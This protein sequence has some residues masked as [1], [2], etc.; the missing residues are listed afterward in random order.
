MLRNLFRKS[1]KQFILLIPVVLAITVSCEKYTYTPPAV[2]PDYAWS[3]QNDIQPI[4]NSS[5]ISCHGGSVA[6]DLRSGK[7][8]N[9]LSKGGYVNLPAEESRLYR[10]MK[11][12][13]HKA[14]ST[15]SEKL[16]VLYWIKQGANNN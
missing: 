7:S 13:D 12:S 3:L 10:K 5:C 16:K 11:A 1:G 2:D 8:W 15:E 14:R 6:P 4:F 9:S